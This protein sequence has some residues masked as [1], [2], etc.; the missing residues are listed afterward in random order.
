[1]DYANGQEITK[2]LMIE[3]KEYLRVNKK[4]KLS[5]INSFLIAANRLFAYL[6]WYGLGVKLYHIQNEAFA[7]KKTNLSLQEHQFTTF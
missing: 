3:F 2:K 5:S 4:Y 1:M 7:S 6:E